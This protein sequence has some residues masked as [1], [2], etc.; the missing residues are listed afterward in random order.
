MYVC[1]YEWMITVLRNNKSCWCAYGDNL[2]S[3]D[4]FI[5]ET[6]LALLKSIV[7]FLLSKI[8]EFLFLF[9]FLLFDFF[10]LLCFLF[11]VLFFFLSNRIKL[12]ISVFLI[13]NFIIII[14]CFILLEEFNSN[15]IVIVL[16]LIVLSLNLYAFS[17]LLC[18]ERGISCLHFWSLKQL[19][20]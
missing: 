19:L 17:I 1:M 10:F 13:K 14:S 5:G 8:L 9:M 3:K 4:L 11:L 2:F 15:I 16:C 12:L 18:I 20:I 7:K 6:I